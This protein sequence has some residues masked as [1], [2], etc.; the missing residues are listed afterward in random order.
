MTVI[1][2]ALKHMLAAGMPHDAIVAAVEEMEAGVASS[3]PTGARS[4]A[5]I[6]QERYRHKKASQNVTNHN[7]VTPEHNNVTENVTGD[8]SV[9]VG[10]AGEFKSPPLPPPP[11]SFPQAPNQPP[12]PPAPP[13]ETGAREA[14]ETDLLG[15]PLPE[16]DHSK[17]KSKPKAEEP[18]VRPDDIPEDAWNGFEEMRRR[19]KAPLTD[20]ARRGIVKRL[21]RFAEDGHP[22]GEVLDQST[23]NSWTDVYALK[24]YRNGTGNR[25]QGSGRYDS[26]FRDPVLAD[27]AFGVRS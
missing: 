22:P 9:T 3:P 27:I 6:R 18:F 16:G 14:Q 2:T 11:P 25:N 1:A 8:A 26:E 23:M 13:C 7:G 24:D 12:P 17:K 10:D 20:R 19:R 21:R 4:K 15:T 5:A